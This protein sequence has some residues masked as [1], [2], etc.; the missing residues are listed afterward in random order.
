MSFI[1]FL[2]VAGNVSYPAKADVRLLA[3][4]TVQNSIP[5]EQLRYLNNSI[6]M[7]MQEQRGISM[8]PRNGSNK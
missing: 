4:K 5:A 2:A 1:I 6:V 8:K 3:R 7:L